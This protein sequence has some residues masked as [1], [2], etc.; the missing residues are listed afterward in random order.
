MPPVCKRCQRE[1]Y[2]FVSCDT[3]GTPDRFDRPRDGERFWGNRFKGSQGFQTAPGT[4]VT[5][6]PREQ[7]PLFIK[8]EPPKAA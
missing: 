7:H 3:V 1:H 2:N 5:L 8:P 4:V 6:I